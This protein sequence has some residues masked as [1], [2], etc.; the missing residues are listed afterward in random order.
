MTDVAALARIDS[1]P[2]QH[3]LREVMSTP[4][5]TGDEGMALDDAIAAMYAARVSSIVGV[6]ADGRALGI[7]TERDLIRLLSTQGCEGLRTTL[8]EAMTRPVAGVDA[9]AFVYVALGKMTRFGYRHLV[10][11][12]RDQ[13]PIG[14]V[15]GRALLKV[16][17]DDALVIGDEVHEAKGPDDMREAI[18]QLPTL[19][20]HLLAEGV[21]ARNIGAVIALVVRDLTARAAELCEAAMAAD[22][23]G[24]APARYA[25][26]VLGSGGR[27]ESL[28][29]FDQD[30][31]IVHAGTA[32]DDPWFAELGR[33]VTTMLNTA[34]IPYCDGGVMASEPKWR[35]SLE[36]WKDEVHGWVFS[37]ENQTVMYCDI[38]FDF[39]PV[40]GD[41]AL[42]EELRA[43]AIDKASQSG[44]FLQYLAMHVATMDVALGLFGGF[45]TRQGRLN[46]KKFALL[47]LVSAARARAIRARLAA[48]GTD[49]RF[50]ALKDMELLH[51]DD[52]R[53]FLEIR[54]IALRMML[55]QQLADIAAGLKP[56]A[57]I[58]PKRFD[59]RGRDRLRWAFKR[60][61][62]LKYICGVAG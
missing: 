22:G 23:W 14:M 61:R 26:L 37:V 20:R 35:M 1:F 19:A 50:A 27:G 40:W 31:A 16:R 25:V 24:A 43:Y 48:T 55:E 57:D 11:L 30:N 51:A 17:A 2:Y 32:A 12:D 39:Q 59:K 53:D 28:L 6:D 56:S 5:L 62:T 60:I 38:F 9:D 41:A 52:W 8:G 42:A 29:S 45:I 49:E 46:V 47:P 7:L 4:V 58:D 18:G 33:R 44:F 13:R 21:S 54:E 10:V 36:Q 15:T 3:R 34:G